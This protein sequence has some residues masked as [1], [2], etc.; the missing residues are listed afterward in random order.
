MTWQPDIVIYHDNCADGFAAAW[1]CRKRWGDACAY[2]PANYGH[3]PPDVA[4]KQ[5]LIVDFSYKKAV[6]EEIAAAAAGVV[7]LDHHKTA[8]ADLNCFSTWLYTGGEVSGLPLDTVESWLARLGWAN[9]PRIVADF[10]MNR[11]GARMAWDFCHESEAPLLIRLVEDRDLWLFKLQDTRPFALWLRSE[12]MT[13]ERFDLI[14]RELALPGQRSTILTEA[15]AMQRFYDTKVD[16]IASFASRRRIGEH[17][18]IAVSCPPM[19]ASDVGNALLDKH[20]D[21]PFAATWFDA[22]RVRMWSL[23]SRDDRVDVSAVAARFGGGGHRNAA[24]FGT[25]LP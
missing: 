13:F 16:E 21:A 5:I 8:E 24:G 14:D 22:P 6:L 3:P 1:A 19:F 11:S 4:G 7:V 12:P 17:D 10:D 9:A 20:A 25:P 18:A 2:V 23:R 15:R